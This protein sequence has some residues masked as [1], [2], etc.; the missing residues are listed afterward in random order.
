M[1]GACDGGVPLTEVADGSFCE[2]TRQRS[3]GRGKGAVELSGVEP[4]TS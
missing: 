4:P 1:T 3:V 2:E